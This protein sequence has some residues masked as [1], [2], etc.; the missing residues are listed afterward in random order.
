MGAIASRI[1]PE[2]DFVAFFLHF[3]FGFLAF[4]YYIST[5]FAASLINFI[6]YAKKTKH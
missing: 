2:W 1:A 4:M 5:S 6:T 3:S